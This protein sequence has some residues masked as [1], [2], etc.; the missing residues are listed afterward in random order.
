MSVD[1]A[2]VLAG[3]DAAV[4]GVAAIDPETIHP[5]DLPGAV[6]QL[7]RARNRLEAVETSW[8]ATV[9]RRQAHKTDGARDAATWAR[10]Q[11]GS[12]WRDAAGQLNTADKLDAL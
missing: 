7:R 2:G 1:V 8:L 3:L 9:Q 11:L 12:S 6:K 5:G 10:D 4:A